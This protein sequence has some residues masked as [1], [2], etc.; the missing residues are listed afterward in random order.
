MNPQPYEN[1][2]DLELLSLM[3]W[4]EAR[5]EIQ[6]AKRAVCCVARNRV[7]AQT[8]FGK[9]YHEVILHPYQFSSF[10]APPRTHITDPNESKWPEDDEAD[11]LDSLDAAK[12]VMDPGTNDVTNGASLYFS[13]PLT[14]PPVSWGAVLPTASIGHLVFWKPAPADLSLTG[15]L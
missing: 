9:T 13:R 4:R 3:C 11:F 15:D 14:M 7:N 8:Y 10:N 12:Q 1:L 6:M 2:S 5:G